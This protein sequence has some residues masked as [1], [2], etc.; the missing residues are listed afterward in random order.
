MKLVAKRLASD[1]SRSK[2][3]AFEKHHGDEERRTSE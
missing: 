3:E 1:H 2:L